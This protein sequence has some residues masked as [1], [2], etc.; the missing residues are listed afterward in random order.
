MGDLPL[1]TPTIPDQIDYEAI[2]GL[3]T[4]AKQK[5]SKIRPETLAQASRISGVNPADL[6][7]LAVYIEQGK[8]AKVK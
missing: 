8:I 7:I 4:E 5:L 1:R 3:A 2:E 6:S